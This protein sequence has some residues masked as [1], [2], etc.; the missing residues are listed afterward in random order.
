MILRIRK[1]RSFKLVCI[2][3]ALNIFAELTWPSYSFALTGGP[4]QPEFAS[5]TPIG[6]T[7]MVDLSSGDMTYNIPL[8]DVGGYPLNIAYSSGI[9]M[10][11]EASMVGLGWNLS[12]G[13]INRNVRGIPDDFKGDELRYENYL[14][15]NITA[16]ANF[17]FTP[18]LAGY[19]I[20]LTLGMAAIY[21][22]Y[23]GFTVK[24]SV[25]I[26]VDL[27]NNASVGFNVESGPD[28][29]SISPSLSIH[30]TSK[31]TTR[32]NVKMGGSIGC[33][34]NTRGGVTQMTM[35]TYASANSYENAGSKEN[36]YN[37]G[38]SPET[39]KS[40]GGGSAISFA[41]QVYTPTKRVGMQT[42]SF[43]VNAALGTE[44]F[45]VEGQGQ[46][47]AYGTVMSVQEG[48]KNK[49][50]RAY[51]YN[52]SGQA[53]K[54]DVLDFNREKDGPVS[55]NT[56]ILPLTNYTYDIYSVQGQGVSGMYRPFQSYVGYVYDPFVQDI[57]LS[58][59]LGLEIGAA[60]TAH[61]GV[62]IEVT[63]VSSH[64]GVW[65]D[66]SP[67]GN[68][69][70]AI[71]K[72]EKTGANIP[73]YETVYF[74]NVG[75][76]SADR[77]FAIFDQ[78]G[79]YQPVRVDIAG[80][81]FNRAALSQFRKKTG[82]NGD[83]ST[84][85]IPSSTLLNR[86]VR[87]Q[88][89]QAIYNLTKAQVL[90]GIGYGPASYDDTYPYIYSGAQPHHI[91]EVQII[92]SDGARYVY[93]QP[94]YN[95][96][97]KEATFA[98]NG[99]GDC[100]T[101]LVPY[102]HSILTYPQNLPHDKYFNR[103]TTPPYVHSHLLTSV[104]STDY[105]DLEGDGPTPDDL[106]AYTKFS[107]TR[108][109]ANY[110]WRI[111]C[112]G[113]MATYNEGLKTNSKDD[114]GSYVYGEKELFY[115]D[116]IVTKTH[117]AKFHYSARKDA[118]GV[119]NESGGPTAT[120]EMFKLDSIQLFSVAEYE[121]AN[122]VPVKVAHFEYSYSL[123]P[124]VPNNI[125]ATL[126]DNELSNFGGKLTL[127]RVF[128]TYRGSNMGRYMGYR[129]NY[130]EFKGGGD[131]YTESLGSLVPNSD[132]TAG[133]TGENPAYHIKSYDTWGNYKPHGGDCSNTSEISAAEFPYTVQDPDEQNTY[134]AVWCMKSIKLPSGGKIDVTYE[135]DDYAYVQN[136]EA[137]RMFTVAAAGHSSTGIISGS[138]YYVD[139]GQNGNLLYKVLPSVTHL[140]Y[141]YIEVDPTESTSLSES[142][143][144]AKYLP[145]L[146]EVIQF[147]FLL[148]MTQVGSVPPPGDDPK[149]DYVSGYF[150]YDEAGTAQIFSRN[151]KKYL[152]IPVKKEYKEGGFVN[153]NDEVN[154]IAKAGWNFGRKYLNNHV[155]SNQPNGDSEDIEALVNELV[156]PQAFNNL[157]EIFEGPNGVLELKGIARQF[158]PEKS[159]IRLMEP[160]NVKL[161]GGNRVKEIR[162]SDAWQDMNP[163]QSNIETMRY[164]QTYSYTLESGLSSGVATYEPIG[165]KE[166]P[167]VQPVASTTQHF[168]A[169]D[170]VNYYE[171]PFG[172]AFFPHP[173]VTYARVSVSSVQAGSEPATGYT[174]PVL[175]ELH[176]TGKVVTEF[177][178]SRDYPTIIDMTR[179]EAEY[180]K[181][182]ALDNILGLNVRKHFTA[183]QGFMI[184]VNDMNG[185]QKSQA[186]YA[187]G[188]SEPI[189]W[190]KYI[191]D[192]NEIPQG[193][194]ASMDPGTNK[195][196]LDNTVR[197]INPDGSIQFKTIGVEVDVVNDFAENST[198]SVTAGVN[199]NLASFII[200]MVPAA[201]PLPLP[202]VATS[203][204]QFRSVSTTKVINTFG[205]LKETI[206]YDAGA[207]VS[208]RNLAWD[209]MTGEVLVTEVTDEYNDRYYTMNYPAHW[210]Y[211]GMG[212]A[213]DNLGLTGTLAFS[214]GSFTI[215]GLP[216]NYSASDL[217]I[218]GDEIFVDG[219]ANEILW[220]TNI[221]GNTFD[222]MQADGTVLSS[223]GSY[224]TNFEVVRSGRRNLQSAG[225]MNVT[226]MHNPL[227]D[228]SGNYLSTIPTN[229]LE[230]ATWDSYKIINA[231]AVDYSNKWKASCECSVDLTSGTYNPYRMNEKGVWRTS[232]SRTY[233]TGRNAQSEVTPRR[234]GYFNTFSPMYKKSPGGNWYKDMTNWTFVARVTKYSPYG[235][236][237][238]NVDALSRYSSAQYG[239]NNTFPVAVG[240]NTRYR[241]I[242]FD[243]FEDYDYDGCD[244]NG[245]FSFKDADVTGRTD[246]EAHTGR[247][248]FKVESSSRATLSKDVD[249]P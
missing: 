3:L 45:A 170:E 47:T 20:D 93:G 187:E 139:P 41:D 56:T 168:L 158:I 216:S 22:N 163:G 199:M 219:S 179:I 218:E 173:Q 169:P 200:A 181:Q 134:A 34:W 176:K 108:K 147:R 21:N 145:N 49:T 53:T 249:C 14:K 82:G 198:Q 25:G 58:S 204:D 138:E 211:D 35:N 104:L 30:A 149:Y 234:E 48:E 4:T 192:S 106:G 36:N 130:N 24:P 245:H 228:G 54:Y 7:D 95:I 105:V 118:H 171:M 85:A 242:G 175:K 6:A 206:A 50:V 68:N 215:A 117:V 38:S 144:E 12:V 197:V 99:P 224:E 11:E 202:D 70:Y 126:T 8:M 80:Q 174:D 135:S 244:A 63:G 13:Q 91:Y 101:G 131:E 222:L 162:I 191:Y 110:K 156:S 232:S 94:A 231:G 159:W 210:V 15:P 81:K 240:A 205:I 196:I 190:V 83:E 28:G 78:T 32:N 37:R 178:T 209:A 55:T 226:L 76:L 154:P 165:N 119:T 208:T 84:V 164:G 235:F 86:L 107:Y 229:F 123:C 217:L 114:Q 189:S 122:P 26:G 151:S 44:V 141:L 237:L 116:E 102:T 233:L 150:R 77:D 238:E 46:I 40:L 157:I 180:D 23:T 183:S 201:I 136:R 223:A 9:S 98:V 18:A 57:S 124:G 121:S 132:Y 230:A 87:Q 19:S 247:H 75:D 167:F 90:D 72:F 239:Y 71:D 1:S 33:T 225:I 160:D 67:G 92:R 127:K 111:P 5:F 103:V 152:S 112:E 100:S 142:E 43:T 195:G 214:G 166:N 120:E 51:G 129:F 115:V 143:I 64:S 193:Y 16:G 203:K 29:M 140:N 42:G 65:G 213:A 148:N 17:E 89:N 184:H 52:N 248:S 207:T 188:Q 62:D 125:A 194:N 31:S 96:T 39:S 59:S 88:R 10:D 109:D 220:V 133:G 73:E 182:E 97:K 74:K 128:F 185:K 246:E 177:Y 227:K 172:E 236:E 153:S 241:E 66:G 79:R 69:N 146:S 60:N 137:R 27:G 61:I 155:Y 221:V 212:Q 113:G 243:G 186:V 2:T 161:G